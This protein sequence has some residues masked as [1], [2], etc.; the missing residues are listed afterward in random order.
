MDGLSN[1]VVINWTLSCNEG[2]C[3]FHYLWRTW[4]GMTCDSK[5]WPNRSLQLST[6]PSLVPWAGKIF[7][8]A[9][10]M[11][12]PP[13]L[14]L[15]LVV[16]TAKALHIADPQTCFLPHQMHPLSAPLFPG[17][18][19]TER[20]SCRRRLHVLVRC[21]SLPLLPG[22]SA[23][24]LFPSGHSPACPYVHKRPWWRGLLAGW[25]CSL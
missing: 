13:P 22:W 3:W 18:G 6:G 2:W 11:H 24:P 9:S 15:A 25:S 12:P 19:N 16:Q 21:H 4:V 23:C 20:T 10:G 7:D 8:P 17:S 14:I 5:T 1:A